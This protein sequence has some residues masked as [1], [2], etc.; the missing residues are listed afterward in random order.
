MA[1][2]TGETRKDTTIN[3]DGNTF[4]DCLFVDC[5]IVYSGGE[6]TGGFT[7]QGCTWELRDAALRTLQ[8]IRD[9]KIPVFE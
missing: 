1:I 8:F 7:T 4:R 5:H 2:F 6:F 9:Y 3:L